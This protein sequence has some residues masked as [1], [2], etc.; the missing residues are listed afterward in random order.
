MVVEK[1]GSGPLGPPSGSPLVILYGN[2]DWEGINEPTFACDI[3]VILVRHSM[4]FYL[5]T[6]QLPH[7]AGPGRV[8]ETPS[9]IE[10]PAQL[11]MRC[12]NS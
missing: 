12:E 11:T 4:V 9:D 10:W 8:L 2:W 1:G 3:V 5:H 7:G 6:I